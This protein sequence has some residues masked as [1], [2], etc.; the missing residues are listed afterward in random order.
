MVWDPTSGLCEMI[1]LFF[2]MLKALCHLFLVT[3]RKYNFFLKRG[4]GL[5]MANIEMNTKIKRLDLGFQ[6]LSGVLDKISSLTYR[7]SFSL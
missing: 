4:G 7:G 3:L 2:Q 5:C 6:A 1:K